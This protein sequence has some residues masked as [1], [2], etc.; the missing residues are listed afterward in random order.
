MVKNVKVVRGEKE[1]NY[2]GGKT[3]GNMVGWKEH[4][5]LETGG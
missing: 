5:V 3:E 1:K 4:E 2:L